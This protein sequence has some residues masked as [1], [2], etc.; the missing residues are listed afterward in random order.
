MD[1]QARA[2]RL[3]FFFW[4][5]EKKFVFN[6]HPGELLLRTSEMKVLF[7]QMARHTARSLTT[8][9]S[10]SDTRTIAKLAQGMTDDLG[11]AD[12]VNQISNYT[13]RDLTIMALRS[14][15]SVGLAKL[16]RATVHSR[17]W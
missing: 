8:K 5:T 9:R 12:A 16:D 11:V 13:S 3:C 2:L 7:L 14:L 10:F 4:S 1:H 17:I 15:E 6:D